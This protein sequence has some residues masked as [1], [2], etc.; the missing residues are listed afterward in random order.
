MSALSSPFW[1][2]FKSPKLYVFTDTALLL[3]DLETRTLSIYQGTHSYRIISPFHAQE[4]TDTAKHKLNGDDRDS[5]EGGERRQGEGETE[6]GGS[7]WGWG[8]GI[9]WGGVD[10]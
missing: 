3:F 7:R 5:G 1:S 2:A 8:P 6:S 10:Y 9:Q 4:R